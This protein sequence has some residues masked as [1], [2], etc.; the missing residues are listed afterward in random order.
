[1]ISLKGEVPAGR[2]G[3]QGHLVEPALGYTL[4]EVRAALAVEEQLPAGL[5]LFVGGG[6]S[7]GGLGHF[8]RDLLLQVRL[9]FVAEFLHGVA[10][11]RLP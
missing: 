7:L 4:P 9:P 6:V 11:G 3:E 10:G 8:G 2:F 5:L 1:M